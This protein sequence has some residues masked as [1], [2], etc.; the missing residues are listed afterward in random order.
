MA[1]D[2]S[3]YALSHALPNAMPRRPIHMSPAEA[4]AQA[5]Q[6]ESEE[7]KR[8]WR[9][10]DARTKERYYAPHPWSSTGRKTVG[11]KM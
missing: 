11:T 9:A 4:I 8:H 6:R 5:W 10:A 1:S 2:S 3:A 7:S